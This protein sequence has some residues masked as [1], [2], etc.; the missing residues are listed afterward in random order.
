MMKSAVILT[1]GF[2]I[3]LAGCTSEAA[4]DPSGTGGDTATEPDKGTGRSIERPYKDPKELMK[5][6]P[7]SKPLVSK[8]TKFAKD[9]PDLKIRVREQAKADAPA[10]EHGHIGKFHLVI[11]LSNGKE[12]E[13]TRKPQIPG[14]ETEP[15][16]FL[17]GSQKQLEGL[18]LA[19]VDMKV[20]EVRHV[21]IP[22]ELGFGDEGDYVRGIPENATLTVRAELVEVVGPMVRVW[23]EGTG[24]GIK[25]GQIGRFDYTGILAKDGTKFDSSREQDKEPLPMPLKLS[26][27]PGEQGGVIEGWV[28]GLMGM[29]VGER[30]WVCVPS[31]L[32]YGAQGN[33]PTIGPHSDLIFEAELVEI[34][35]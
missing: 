21:I 30:R 25:R 2:A 13:N 9:F 11:T 33:G 17:A 20:G 16:M 32:G 5:P 29:K 34:V 28:L 24:E 12:V 23:K 4:E 1:L 22:P 3:V 15:R 8:Q 6:P 35:R 18:G 27:D 14:T 19:V 26:T 10:L 31:H 7:D